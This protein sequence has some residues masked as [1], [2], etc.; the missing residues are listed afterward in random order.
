MKIIFLIT[1]TFFLSAVAFAQPKSRQLSS[2]AVA[3]IRL[4]LTPLKNSWIYF[5]NYYGKDD[6]FQLADSALLNN[7][8]TAILRK[9]TKYPKGIYIV[10]SD[11]KTR[12]FELLMGDDQVF[13][14]AADTSDFSNVQVTG[15]KD[16]TLYQ[17]YTKFLSNLASKLNEIKRQ[18]SG[19]PN[20][21]DSLKLQQE[22][23]KESKK[24]KDY[25]ETVSKENPGTFIADVF[26]A[27]K[28]PVVPELPNQ[29]GGKA[30]SLYPFRYTKEHYWDDFG[31]D[32][33]GLVRTPVIE[34]KLDEYFRYYV[35]PHA[36]S[37][38]SEIK[39][40]L[41]YARE[42][43]EMYRYLLA[44]FTNKYISPEI[45][46]QDKVFLYLF[47]EHY[48]KGDTSLLTAKDKKTIMDR[49]WSLWF[50]QIDEPAA[51]L[52]LVTAAG[53]KVSLHNQKAKYT[54]VV[55]WDP[56]C[57]HCKETLPKIDSLY[58]S[59]WKAVGLKIYAVNID[60]SKLKAWS[61]FINKHSLN[62][63]IHVYQSKELIEAEAAISAVNFRQAYDVY[64]TPTLYLL[65]ENKKIIAK[66]L[67]LAGIDQVLTEKEKAKGKK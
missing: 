66:Q 57:G 1:G 60:N 14:I 12:L 56:D 42:A 59:K 22:W 31:F 43:K 5:Y 9:S 40:M 65:D 62:E 54:A 16:N 32:N 17:D 21:E 51:P 15:S 6:R 35:S 41:L 28:L 8:S 47:R 36:D 27:M 25:R 52:D 39:Y 24:M 46:G 10:V 19:N 13:S 48:L 64:K 3:E 23:V 26:N 44:R 33:D 61:E 34:P 45:M 55:F 58:R 18:L 4:T 63:W 11:R 20:R 49:G 7:Q 30:D 50:N 38:I 53:I 37:I 2:P 29:S 67:D